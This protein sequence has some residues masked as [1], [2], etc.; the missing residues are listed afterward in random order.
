MNYRKLGH[1]VLRV[2]EIC[3]GGNIFGYFCDKEETREIIDRA[4]ERGVNF[5]DTANVYSHG[6]SEEYIGSAV[7]GRRQDFVIATK[8][9]MFS[10][11][12]ARNIFKKEYIL[13]SAYES[14]KRLKTDYIDLYQI[15]NVDQLLPLS[16][17]M[18]ALD[19]L[20]EEGVIRYAGCSNYN[21]ESLKEAD[22]LAVKNKYTSLQ[23]PYSLLDRNVEKEIL[24]FCRR[25]SIGVL[26]YQALARGLLSGK[27]KDAS[28]LPHGSRAARR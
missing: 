4:H 10:D 18:E 22:E 14:L 24:P 28:K 15:H 6:I 13:R 17:A 23:V 21:I 20:V 27:Y 19:R 1:S 25:L 9:G 5:I 12:V 11:Q 16:E 7:K 2:S 3:L 8:A 26:P